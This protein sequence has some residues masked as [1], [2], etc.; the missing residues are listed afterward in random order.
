[1]EGEK[2]LGGNWLR[3]ERNGKGDS[4]EGV[5]LLPGEDRFVC[6]PTP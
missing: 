2:K 1:L 6:D 4:L 3:V 5:L